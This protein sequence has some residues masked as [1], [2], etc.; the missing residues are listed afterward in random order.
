MTDY[1][2]DEERIGGWIIAHSRM[3]DMVFFGVFATLDE[4]LEFFSSHELSGNI[5]PLVSPKSDPSLFW[6]DLYY[7]SSVINS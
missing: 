6:Q 3:N 7:P 2:L 5:V 1:I 4:A